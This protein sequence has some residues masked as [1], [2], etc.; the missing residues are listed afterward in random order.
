MLVRNLT[1][2]ATEVRIRQS[3]GHCVGPCR[4][5]QA[6]CRY[7]RT[8]IQL[9]LQS[10][11]TI[12][13]LAHRRFVDTSLLGNERSDGSMTPLGTLDDVAD[14]RMDIPPRA[15][16]ERVIVRANQY[17]RKCGRMKRKNVD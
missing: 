9:F 14:W 11:A 7:G 15:M 2:S 3:P 4:F 13:P 8:V 1:I 12:T 5:R 10:A 17:R 6:S 16:A